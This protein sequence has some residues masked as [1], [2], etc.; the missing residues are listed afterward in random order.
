MN[1]IIQELIDLSADNYLTRVK[2]YGHVAVDKAQSII[3]SFR[4]A[5]VDGYL[6]VYAGNTPRLYIVADDND[7]QFKKG[8]MLKPVHNWMMPARTAGTCGNV[9]NAQ[10]SEVVAR[11]LVY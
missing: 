7:T 4:I 9:F 10:D 1:R 3:N 6:C 8:D 5:P 11:R 2:Y